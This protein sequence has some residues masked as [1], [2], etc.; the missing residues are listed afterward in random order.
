MDG[1]G[2][3]RS[4]FLSIL[5]R[6]LLLP[7][8]RPSSLLLV[9]AYALSMSELSEE[10]LS[11]LCTSWRRLSIPWLAISA[12][13]PGA[14]ALQQSLASSAP[15]SILRISW[16]EFVSWLWLYLFCFDGAMGNADFRIPRLACCP[17]HVG[18]ND[19]LQ[20]VVYPYSICLS[21]G[22]ICCKLIATVSL[23]SNT[24][25]AILDKLVSESSCLWSFRAF[26]DGSDELVEL[27][28]VY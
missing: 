7:L 12:V 25:A 16:I 5:R 18:Q 23:Q 10:R 24:I 26:C 4:V 2:D 13:S 3:L 14:I 11:C 6:P 27:V 21:F 8:L 17:F 1:D 15:V 28:V 9:I 22:R 19:C 20:I